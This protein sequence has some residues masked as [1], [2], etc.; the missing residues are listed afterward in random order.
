MLALSLVSC[1]LE[2][3]AY[4]G[5]V[6]SITSPS[7][8]I[9]KRPANFDLNG[10]VANCT[11]WVTSS[12]ATLASIKK[13]IK[14]ADRCDRGKEVGEVKFASTL[15]LA[16]SKSGTGAILDL[17]GL[18]DVIIDGNG[19]TIQLANDY[20]S[21]F[22]SCSDCK[23]VIIKNFVFNHKGTGGSHLPFTQ[24]TIKAKIN[25]RK[26]TVKLDTGYPQLDQGP[27]ASGVP[28]NNDHAYLRDPTDP[29]KTLRHSLDR[30]EVTRWVRTPGTSASKR[31]WDV[32]FAEAEPRAA[33][34]DRYVQY[35]RMKENLRGFDPGA[36]SIHLI[37]C[38][39]IVVRDISNATSA[40]RFVKSWDSKR[41][42]IVYNT[43]RPKS[44]A[45]MSGAAAMIAVRGG[46]DVWVEGN[47]A[48]AV[49]DDAIA[50]FT[51]DRLLTI[52]DGFGIWD[53]DV[54]T[55]RTGII[56][57]GHN[58]SVRNNTITNTGAGGIY[59]NGHNVLVDGNYLEQNFR[60]RPRDAGSAGRG[61]ISSKKNA[62]QKQYGLIVSNNT[63]R[64]WHEVAGIKVFSAKR[65]GTDPA[66]GLPYATAVVS[67]NSLTD[68]RSDPDQTFP[69]SNHGSKAIVVDVVSD[70]TDLVD[71]H[72]L[73]GLWTGFL[74]GSPAAVFSQAT[75]GT[76]SGNTVD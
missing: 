23:R 26:F 18:R 69:A 44:G 21:G 74:T 62:A 41:V 31:K 28:G 32:T 56:V 6:K 51:V 67:G 3:G 45:D 22:I 12:S 71:N 70:G 76:V 72:I 13:K 35:I 73:G 46:N 58:G 40:G 65:P 57:T 15:R 66:T 50:F 7:P 52:T 54:T 38:A 8:L 19:A 5:D 1:L 61:I 49:G 30:L 37:N 43:M 4:E 29:T 33:V 59:T 39:D 64:S 48:R 63:L 24:G 68:F 20:D 10:M 25:N 34:G 16:Y 75:L 27:F 60:G 36:D 14:K 47:F 42:S 9:M 55:R 11:K 17:S 53:N 2:E